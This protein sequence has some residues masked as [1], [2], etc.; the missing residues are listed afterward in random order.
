MPFKKI[1][2]FFSGPAPHISREE[3]MSVFK[4]DHFKCQYC[5][6]DGLHNFSNWLVLTIDHVH[7]RAKGGGR[8]MANLVTCCQP[9]NVLKGHRI[10]ASREAAKKF[11][12]EKRE[13]WH[14]VFEE[15]VKSH[16]KASVA[17]Q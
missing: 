5:G 4:R 8:N 10:F 13:E 16:G 14:R 15:Q 7:P 12:L 2:K 11:V 9:C 6:L 17:A 1:V 3:A